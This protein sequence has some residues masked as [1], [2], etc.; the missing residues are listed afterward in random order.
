IVRPR[1]TAA[2]TAPGDE[3]AGRWVSPMH[4]EIVK[5]GPGQCDICGMD[6]VPAEELGV[7]SDDL[8]IEE[9]IVVPRSSV[10]ITG[11]R[12]VV[13]V[14]VPNFDQPT[15]EGREVVLGPRAGDHY[16]VLKGLD[17]GDEVVVNGAF[18]LD[19]E[20]QIRAKP[21]MMDPQS[22]DADQPSLVWGGKGSFGPPATGGSG[23]A[24][25][26]RT[27]R[28]DAPENV[29]FAL[30][31]VYSM[32]FNVQ[33]AL[34]DDDFETF[35]DAAADLALARQIAAP[36]G[37]LGEALGAWRR[38]MSKLPDTNSVAAI[39]DIEEARV[40]FET[41][42]AGVLDLQRAFGHRGTQMFYLA[43]CPMA[44]DDEG[45]DW[46]QRQ[47]TIDNPYFGAMM[48]RCGEIRREYAPSV[49]V[50][51]ADPGSSSESIDVNRGAIDG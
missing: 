39:D 46:L 29:M 43:H 51:P 26:S 50:T 11:Q 37:L 16:I 49:P 24:G 31:P 32:Y 45:A 30:T 20:M 40:I 42:S 18:R 12:A 6:L 2:G 44:F 10:M 14:R 34:A 13:Y 48:L 17:E 36:T 21:S 35:K 1:V 41:W 15:F 5:D 27:A 7:V 19:S 9:P 47:E 25:S 4:P 33:E 22:D 23:G 3:L 38:A 8:S 28:Y